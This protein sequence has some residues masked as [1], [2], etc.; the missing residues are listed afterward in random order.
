MPAYF[1][2]GF[3]V[4]EPMWHG[5]GTIV[6]EYP[7]REEAMRL[8]GHDFI[9][10]EQPVEIPATFDEHGAY[11]A[12]PLTGWKALVKD[13]G[14]EDE[15]DGAVLNVVKDSYT[16]IQNETGWDVVDAI[17]GEGAKYETGITMKN[18][19]VCSVLAYLPEPTVIPGDDSEI[20]PWVNV[21][22]AHDG[23][24]SLTARATSIRTVCWNTQ[25]AAEAQGKRFGTDF[26]FRHTKNVMERI[27]D[28]K[29]AIAGV[30]TGHEAFIEIARELAKTPVTAEQRELFICTLVPMPPEALIS[31]RVMQNVEDARTSIR[32]LFGGKT[33][34]EAHE[35]T[36]YGLHLAGTEFL[37]HLRGYRNQETYFGRSVLR[38]EP[39]KMKMARIIREVVKS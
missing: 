1:D 3:A 18:G 30:R 25:S 5:L 7:G 36:A 27:E 29:E 15:T 35:L 26:T 32:L 17:V 20:L 24:A 13:A 9:V 28:A 38:A 8:A 31:E 23:S 14:T 34:P 37:D 19:A 10:T 33:I 16:V 11:P 4:R 12:K 21:S 6:E 2:C 22:W 39:A